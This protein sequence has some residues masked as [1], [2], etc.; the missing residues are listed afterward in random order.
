MSEPITSTSNSTS[1]V[2]VKLYDNDNGVAKNYQFPEGTI[3]ETTNHRYKINENGIQ[4]FKTHHG[5]SGNNHYEYLG[6]SSKMEIP[7]I[8]PQM[9]AVG[10]FDVNKDRKIDY[11]DAK[12]SDIVEVAYD[13]DTGGY[14]PQ[15]DNIA[16]EI[17]SRLSRSNSSFFAGGVGWSGVYVDKEEGTF[18]VEFIDSRCISEDNPYGWGN[19]KSLSIFLPKK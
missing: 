1:Y 9:V 3:F 12:N 15:G 19:D 6:V 13:E 14:A 17:N 7:V 18:G 2:T 16:Y 11:Y 4:K 5:D 10:V 8:L